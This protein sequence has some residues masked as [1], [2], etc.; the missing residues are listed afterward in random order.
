MPFF[1]FFIHPNPLLF[2]CVGFLSDMGALIRAYTHDT[3]IPGGLRRGGLTPAC[4]SAHA[5]KTGSK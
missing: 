1:A 2:I 4:G 3:M 5:R